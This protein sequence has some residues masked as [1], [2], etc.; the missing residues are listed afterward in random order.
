MKN[1]WIP[2]SSNDDQLPL[3][4]IINPVIGSEDW[5][6]FRCPLRGLSL[7]GFPFQMAGQRTTWSMCGR[8]GI[9]YNW[10]ATYLFLEASNWEHSVAV[11]VTWQQQQVII[12][13]HSGSLSLLSKVNTLVFELIYYSP[14]NSRSSWSQSTC[15]AQWLCQCLGCLSGSII[16][17]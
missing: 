8:R 11:I 4:V 13:N 16:K 10:L 2:C 17:R 12:D 6:L 9:R 1:R 3:N 14:D 5:I 15:H 7:N